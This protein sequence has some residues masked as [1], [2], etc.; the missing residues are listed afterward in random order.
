MKRSF[1]FLLSARA[2][3]VNTVNRKIAELQM[4]WFESWSG[5]DAGCNLLVSGG[6]AIAIDVHAEEVTIKDKM[7]RIRCGKVILRSS[8]PIEY[9]IYYDGGE[10]NLIQVGFEWPFKFKASNGDIYIQMS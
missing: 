4:W 10:L 2:Y 6:V 1:N 5:F 8:R 9:D 3:I 7:F